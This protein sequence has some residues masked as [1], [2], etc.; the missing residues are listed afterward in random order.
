MA[1]KTNRFPLPF[2]FSFIAHYGW[3]RVVMD[4]KWIHFLE[5]VG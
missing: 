4:K 5:K 1:G 3:F 2:L